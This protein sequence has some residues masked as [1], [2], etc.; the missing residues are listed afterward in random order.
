MPT[1]RQ[2]SYLVAVA[3]ELHFRQAAERVHVSQPTLSL[4]IAALEKRLGAQLI[5]R[6]RTGIALTPIGKEVVDRARWI[7]DQVQEITELTEKTSFGLSGKLGVGAPASIGPYILPYIVPMLRKQ[8][9]LLKLY[10]NE[11]VKRDALNDLAAGKLDIVITALP[12]DFPNFSLEHLF[13]EQMYVCIPQDNALFNKRKIFKKDL[14]G[15]KVLS[16]DRRH[17]IYM[18]T[19]EMCDEVGANLLEEYAGPSLDSVLQMV[20]LNA[21]ISVFPGLF[22]NN[23][24]GRYSDVKL[25]KLN[26]TKFEREIGL[27]WRRANPIAK[28]Y[29]KLAKLF[30]AAIK[31]IKGI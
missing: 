5:D 23:I 12:V 30:S 13:T 4:Q 17:A 1:L 21:G 25:I 28:E 22:A 24:A 19:R 3:D 20:R 14:A 31:Q 27:V 18:Q 2:L 29:Q 16:L 6:A 11:G 15:Q 9:P 26:D 7:L 10:F 8:Y